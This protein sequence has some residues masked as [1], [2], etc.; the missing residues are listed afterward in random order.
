MTKFRLL[1]IFQF[2]HVYETNITNLF[3]D[4]KEEDI[5]TEEIGV[6]AIESELKP[7]ESEETTSE[8]TEDLEG[9]EEDETS[10]WSVF[11]CVCGFIYFLKFFLHLHAIFIVYNI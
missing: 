11:Q 6:E 7:L 2:L 9:G 1:H 8:T 4:L 5:E 3:K 10:F